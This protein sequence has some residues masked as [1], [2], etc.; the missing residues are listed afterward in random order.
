M[1]MKNALIFVFLWI[2]FVSPSFG[3]P[4]YTEQLK[5]CKEF[6]G[7]DT[8]ILAINTA[9]QFIKQ[10]V[11]EVKRKMSAFPELL[12]REDRA[13]YCQPFQSAWRAWHGDATPQ[14]A[15]LGKQMINVRALKLD[16]CGMEMQKA[17]EALDKD[18]RAFDKFNRDRCQ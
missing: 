12:S 17:N 2:V 3:A 4:G 10:K 8:E 16:A 6:I 15:R 7:R 18:G 14:N 5:T 11:E 9:P 1:P 13:K